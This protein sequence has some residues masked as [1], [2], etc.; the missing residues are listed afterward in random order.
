MLKI[1]K[2][3]SLLY[4]LLSSFALSGQDLKNDLSHE[5]NTLRT[6]KYSAINSQILLKHNNK[7]LLDSLKKFDNDTSL[8][9]RFNIQLL[10]YKIA[11]NNISDTA[12][13]HEVITRLIL[14]IK[15]EDRLIRQNAIK[16]LMTFSFLDFDKKSINS[17]N[18]TINSTNI[19]SDLIL[20]IGVANIQEQKDYLLKNVKTYPLNKLSDFHTTNWAMHL[21]LARMGNTENINYCIKNVENFNDSIFRVKVL[22]SDLGFIRTE[23]AVVYIKKYLYNNNRMPSVEGILKGSQYCQYALD[24]LASII[25]DFPIKAQGIGYSGEEIE[26]AKKW[27]DSHS[28]YKIKR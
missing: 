4:F 9:I 13:K 3:N 10:E 23:A 1:I 22:L 16:K 24:V 12:I 7:V 6:N 20:L 21:A 15:D 19:T 14:G 5:I 11:L 28:Q 2:Y 25:E 18:Q 26:V 8:N 27:M 17:L